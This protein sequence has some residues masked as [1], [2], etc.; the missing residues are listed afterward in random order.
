MDILRY[1]LRYLFRIVGGFLISMI[2]KICCKHVDISLI[3]VHRELINIYQFKT[4]SKM[5]MRKYNHNFKN[6]NNHLFK[7]NNFT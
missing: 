7:F 6:G 3:N 5:T 2:V 1:A 4:A